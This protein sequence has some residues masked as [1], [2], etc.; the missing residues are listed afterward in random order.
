MN[1]KNLIENL[2]GKKTLG[3]NRI[4]TCFCQHDVQLPTDFRSFG[5]KETK[6]FYSVKEECLDKEFETRKIQ[7]EQ[8]MNAKKLELELNTN[9]VRKKIKNRTR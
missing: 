9:L 5:T 2:R 7:L 1:L 8:L 6:W 4:N 3:K